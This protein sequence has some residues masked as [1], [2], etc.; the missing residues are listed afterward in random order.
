MSGWSHG[1]PRTSARASSTGTH[2]HLWQHCWR[3]FS[4]ANHILHE[5][6]QAAASGQTIPPMLDLHHTSATIASNT[7]NIK[8]TLKDHNLVF[9]MLFLQML[10]YLTIMFT[11][12]LPALVPMQGKWEFTKD[13]DA[14][15]GENDTKNGKYGPSCCGLVWIIH[16]YQFWGNILQ[17]YAIYHSV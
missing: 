10:A 6:S 12:F 3:Y 8:T 4:L 13:K 17:T 2:T 7:L 14:N 16:R 1:W 9:I 11:H 15:F 5:L